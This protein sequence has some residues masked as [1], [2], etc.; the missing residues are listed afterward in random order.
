MRDEI[1]AVCSLSCVVIMIFLF[2]LSIL[3]TDQID[4]DPFFVSQE[5]R[6][7]YEGML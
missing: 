4:L 2:D 7:H 1:P 3:W 6:R 5:Y